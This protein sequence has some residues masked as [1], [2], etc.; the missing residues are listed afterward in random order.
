MSWSMYRKQNIRE[1][2]MSLVANYMCG[3]YGQC[4]HLLLLFVDK[5]DNITM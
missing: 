5:Q 1:S 3:L 4:S 2:L